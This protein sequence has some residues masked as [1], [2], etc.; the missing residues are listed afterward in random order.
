MSFNIGSIDLMAYFSL[1]DA[2]NLNTIK[3]IN[4]GLRDSRLKLLLEWINNKKVESLV[5]TGNKLTDCCL[6]M[7]LRRSLPFLKE[8]YLGKNRISKQRMKENIMEIRSK[9]ILYL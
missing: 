8:I 6:T 5:L 9:F 4:V 7:F 2:E 1:F 3:L